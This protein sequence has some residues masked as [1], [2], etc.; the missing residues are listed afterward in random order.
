MEYTTFLPGICSFN[1][2]IYSFGGRA[3]GDIYF[4]VQAYDVTANF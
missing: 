4:L 3:E 2:K 1:E